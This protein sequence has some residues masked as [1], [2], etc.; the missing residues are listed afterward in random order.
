MARLDNRTKILRKLDSVED[1]K[2]VSYSKICD[3]FN[4]SKP[5]HKSQKLALIKTFSEF[6]NVT[7]LPS[8]KLTLI[9][10]KAD[11]FEK[12]LTGFQTL[13]INLTCPSYEELCNQFNLCPSYDYER[14]FH[15]K[16]LNRCFNI[17]YDLNGYTLVKRPKLISTRERNYD[18]L[19]LKRILNLLEH[20]CQE[21]TMFNFF[22]STD[23][24]FSV[25]FNREAIIRSFDLVT[26]LYFSLDDLSSIDEPLSTYNLSQLKYV[27]YELDRQI[28]DSIRSVVN[29]INKLGLGEV[30]STY[31]V[32]FVNG[33]HQMADHQMFTLI[34]K[35]RSDVASEFNLKHTSSY[36]FQLSAKGKSSDFYTRLLNHFHLLDLQV[37]NIRKVRLIKIHRNLPNLLIGLRVRLSK[38]KQVKLSDLEKLKLTCLNKLQTEYTK[39]INLIKEEP[40]LTIDEITKTNYLLTFFSPD[41]TQLLETFLNLILIRDSDHAYLS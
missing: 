26:D 35:C 6:F 5:T 24:Y 17:T 16:Q 22:N 41:F 38:L 19:T 4:L 32:N 18:Y 23:L 9:K 28:S 7:E 34:E 12:L 13:P 31:R 15:L 30:H 29:G 3:Y 27:K 14:E 36:D 25:E 8:G 11:A 40:S 2:E 10:R 21:A 37:T 1:L 33:S 20:C 39:L